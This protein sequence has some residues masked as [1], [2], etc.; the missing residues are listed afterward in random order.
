MIYNIDFCLSGEN[1]SSQTLVKRIEKLDS[2]ANLI[3]PFLMLHL[4]SLEE[5][6]QLDVVK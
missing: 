4:I 1:W 6:Y 2:T 5:S 3:Y